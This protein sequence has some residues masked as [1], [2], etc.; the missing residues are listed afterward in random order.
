MSKSISMGGNSALK[1][2]YG[3]QSEAKR[4]SNYRKNF[5]RIKTMGNWN[6]KQGESRSSFISESEYTAHEQLWHVQTVSDSIPGFLFNL[7]PCIIRE[8]DKPMTSAVKLY[9]MGDEGNVF[10][11]T[12]MFRPYFLLRVDFEEKAVQVPQKLHDSHIL[13]VK[14]L[15]TTLFG[16]DIYEFDEVMLLDTSLYDHLP[17]D[18]C[19]EPL[20][21]FLKVIC[22]SSSALKRVSRTLVNHKVDSRPSIFW[23]DINHP[24]P[25]LSQ[26][27]IHT[28]SSNLITLCNLISDVRE[29]D[30]DYTIQ[31]QTANDVHIGNWYQVED[32]DTYDP[33]LVKMT[34]PDRLVKP[35]LEIFAYDIECMH[36]PYKFPNMDVD[37]IMCISIM[38]N[39]YGYLITNLETF[40]S[41]VNDFNYM[42][43]DFKLINCATEKECIQVFFDLLV[44][45]KPQII[46]TYNGD[47]FD[48]PYI[49]RR[50]EVLGISYR[51]YGFRKKQMRIDDDDF[52]CLHTVAIHVDCFYWV[53]RDSYLPAGSHGLKAVTRKKLGYEPF[54]LNANQMVEFGQTNP[55]RLAEYAVSDAYATEK[56]FE[57]YILN[58]IFALG[59]IL[60]I[61]PDDILRKGSGV[62]CECLLLK[63]ATK[64]NLAVPNSNDVI[65]RNRVLP[66]YKNGFVKDLSFEGG[67]VRS[68][69][70]GIYRSDF[71]IE[72]EASPEAYR[73]LSDLVEDEIEYYLTHEVSKPDNKVT[74]DDF[75]NYQEVVHE[76]RKA[77][78]DFADELES[79]K[80]VGLTQTANMTLLTP[81]SDNQEMTYYKVKRKP[82]IYHLDVGAMYPNIIL[83]NRLQPNAV[84]AYRGSS[85]PKECVNCSFFP[86]RDDIKCQ[87]VLE[88]NR[89]ITMF[90]LDSH[91]VRS[92]YR[93]V[94][95][96][97]SQPKT[98]EQRVEFIE[99]LEDIVKKRAIK[100]N[101]VQSRLISDKVPA[102]VCQREHSFYI[103]TVEDFRDRRYVF[104]G[105]AKVYGRKV[106]DLMDQLRNTDGLSEFQV[107]D[108]R[109]DLEQNSTL[110]NYY[111]S[112]QLAH[113][114]ILNSFYGYVAKKGAKWGN[115]VMGGIVT[116][117]GG[118]IISEAQDLL[119]KL[120]N[121]LELDTDGIWSCL[122]DCFPEN[123]NF[124]FKETGKKLFFSY[125]CAILN[126]RTH[127]FCN[128]AQFTRFN[129]DTNQYST[130]D[131]QEI[132][133]EVDGPYK[134]MVLPA[135]TEEGKLLKKRYVV[136]NFD[137][138]LAELKGFELKRRGELELIKEYQQKLFDYYLRGSTLETAYEEVANTSRYFLD[139]IHFRGEAL[140]D[141]EVLH[142]FSERKTLSRNLSEYPN[143]NSLL[144]ACGRKMVHFLG[145][146]DDQ[147]ANV[148][149]EFVILKYPRAAELNDRA[150][151][152][153]ILRLQNVA[154]RKQYLKRML[155]SDAAELDLRDLLDW[156]YYLK[157][158]SQQLLK[159]VIIPAVLQNIPNPMPEVELPRW[160][161]SKIKNAN[162]T[163]LTLDSFFERAS[164]KRN[165]MAAVPQFDEMQIEAVEDDT[166]P[167]II[168]VPSMMPSSVDFVPVETEDAPGF[169]SPK[170]P[171]FSPEDHGPA[172]EEV[173]IRKK[174]SEIV[175]FETV[176][177][178]KS[179]RKKRTSV[180]LR[181][182]DIFDS[183]KHTL[184]DFENMY[185][186]SVPPL[187][188]AA[189][190]RTVL[191]DF[192]RSIAARRMKRSQELKRF[193]EGGV[194]LKTSRA[195]GLKLYQSVL[196]HT[197][198][199]AKPK[200][201]T[202]LN[203][204]DHHIS[205]QKGRKRMTRKLTKSEILHSQMVIVG[206]KRASGGQF[207][208]QVLYD[209][210][211]TR[212]SRNS[213]T[214]ALSSFMF[215]MDHVFYVST[216]DSSALISQLK[217]QEL[218]TEEWK[219]RVLSKHEAVSFLAP[220]TTLPHDVVEV[221]C[222]YHSN[223]LVNS[224]YI[225]RE[226][227]R[228]SVAKGVYEISIPPKFRCLSQLP[229]LLVESREFKEPVALSQIQTPLTAKGN[230][231][232]FYEA[233]FVNG[234]YGIPM[235]FG[236]LI[237]AGDNVNCAIVVDPG[238][239]LIEFI[240]PHT[241]FLL[242]DFLNTGLEAFFS[243][244][245]KS[246]PF[247]G[248]SLSNFNVTRVKGND[249][250]VGTFERICSSLHRHDSIFYV[251]A[252]GFKKKRFAKTGIFFH[253]PSLLFEGTLRTDLNSCFNMIV[254]KFSGLKQ[255]MH[256]RFAIASEFII[257][258]N[259]FSDNQEV[260]LCDLL[261]ARAIRKAKQVMWFSQTKNTAI[262]L[263]AEVE[264]VVCTPDVHT[265]V[266]AEV[267]MPTLFFRALVEG[268]AR[269]SSAIIR[270]KFAS[271]FEL[272]SMV[273]NAGR[274][275]TGS[276]MVSIFASSVDHWI[277]TPESYF[278]DTVFAHS[279]NIVKADFLKS[280]VSKFS[281]VG[282]VP[283]HINENRLLLA[284][285]QQ[286]FKQARF[287]I[288]AAIQQINES[289]DV[290]FVV[291][292]Y[293]SSC[294]VIDKTNF[295]VFQPLLSA[296]LLRHLLNTNEMT[297]YEM[298]TGIPRAGVL[299]DDTVDDLSFEEFDYSTIK[300]NKYKAAQSL[301]EKSIDDSVVEKLKNFERMTGLLYGFLPQM[302]PFMMELEKYHGLE[303][304]VLQSIVYVYYF[305][306]Y[307]R[308]REFFHQE[309]FFDLEEQSL[310]TSYEH[311]EF[312]DLRPVA[313]NSE[314]DEFNA[315]F[316]QWVN[317]AFL[318]FT[319]NQM[320][321]VQTGEMQADISTDTLPRLYDVLY[322]M[323]IV[324]YDSEILSAAL[325]NVMRKVGVYHEVARAQDQDES[326]HIP[327]KLKAISC[328]DCGRSYS[329]QLIEAQRKVLDDTLVCSKCRVGLDRLSFEESL[330]YAL[331]SLVY[332]FATQEYSCP[333]CK[334]VAYDGLDDNRCT[335]G[336][337]PQREFTEA[338]YK[339]AL[340][341]FKDI[342]EKLK[343]Y[344]VLSI[345]DVYT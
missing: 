332:G 176:K 212:L 15:L 342:A 301:I 136:F 309:Q 249:Q 171:V 169:R 198:S 92:S 78:L 44:K 130:E 209:P 197:S 215:V 118:S 125:P 256:L 42:N 173:V 30:I 93:E 63:N 228:L 242:D 255:Q 206:I 58:F 59:L 334:M 52:E 172:D 83:T 181:L 262:P 338:V 11:V 328:S 41:P 232:D 45:H 17:K 185:G 294:V 48:F 248:K 40:S 289:I 335:C 298:L 247:N 343:L 229:A 117:I 281:E 70:A 261:M 109:E 302:T 19:S 32:G 95:D 154:Q 322:K 162:T 82:L 207:N 163:Q 60:P 337:L 49:Y 193:S 324:P 112:L 189:T 191:H 57:K 8:K 326:N 143:K 34:T 254:H 61:G 222:P 27:M 199:K 318:Q 266:I 164:K 226:I 224:H 84:F 325:S 340:S 339:D 76:I 104:K 284:T 108:I 97:R 269:K 86:V 141:E 280:I 213:D 50:C 102:V 158:F 9:F 149:I 140:S 246:W 20:V 305:G 257:P 202:A 5:S 320:S 110:A 316:S 39:H 303:R 329:F 174:T 170:S 344:A 111:D 177:K 36:Q 250:V 234:K 55:Q 81:S 18:G 333:R 271:Y 288:D 100:S 129:Y 7:R 62:L 310:K 218:V 152:V 295:I 138:S 151:P 77:L 283:V 187:K 14:S 168:G 87:R 296:D 221:S 304:E 307:L 99:E 124:I 200:T 233:A 146:S 105:K 53:K 188:S 123:Y 205:T 139:L 167:P 196:R 327:V 273:L 88:W 132:F 12:H 279:L 195:E 74:K 315:H 6:D 175:E 211:H 160:V 115:K 238:N 285:K 180:Q 1:S 306:L 3:R 225:K 263:M 166:M 4:T 101:R 319:I 230:P 299:K 330:M 144:V 286:T 201:V 203:H 227:E 268:F 243:S 116:N 64:R 47:G 183:K 210:E 71:P 290:E 54:E 267:K 244:K 150:F 323:L 65:F 73:E 179:T 16:E 13:E 219:Y 126:R 56:L 98:S 276:T 157:R 103:D 192:F 278:H 66:L 24:L 252:D 131:R 85:Q 79:G 67:T 159:L 94:L 46:I 184:K 297:P 341:L 300:P 239:D 204:I 29:F 208:A 25:T 235:R 231:A 137:G 89:K 336:C 128:N 122:P 291:S 2:D 80:A 148:T 293:Y 96:V 214:L 153:N 287:T 68:L 241:M 308:I 51:D 317:G 22:N 270:S 23:Q 217:E 311:C 28:G 245:L 259:N 107:M 292:N 155:G 312:S 133:F 223:I 142:L 264:T 135:S 265:N 251:F 194:T 156:D 90:N 240:V 21:P 331:N 91:S 282:L 161:E 114:C 216:I 120:G 69:N 236:A 178:R 75:A 275:S 186:I 33:L 38:M 127:T 35:E 119:E 31:Y 277:N 314:V 274:S 134:A 165:Q 237:E 37:E 121:N 10:S 43:T 345:I 145:L 182:T 113:K 260:L 313:Y 258:I 253:F 106:Q 190:S 26:M 272:I 220:I 147:S 321:R 72:F